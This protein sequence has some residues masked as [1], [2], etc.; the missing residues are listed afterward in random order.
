LQTCF[1]ANDN[2]LYTATCREFTHEFEQTYLSSLAKVRIEP[3]AGLCC[4]V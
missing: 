3:L 2:T 1:E 4:T